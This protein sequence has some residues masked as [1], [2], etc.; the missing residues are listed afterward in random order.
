MFN[1][2]SFLQQ[3]EENL[4]KLTSKA[5][6]AVNLVTSTINELD[7][8]N[9]EITN[10]S[11]KIEEEITKLKSVKNSLSNQFEQNSKIISNFGKL[12]Q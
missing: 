1:K 12:L 7:E 3:Q 2:K 11:N 10:T 9:K 8:T 6:A 4:V 5:S